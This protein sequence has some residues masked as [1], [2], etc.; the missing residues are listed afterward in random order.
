MD[1]TEANETQ[2][3][4]TTPPTS[5]TSDHNDSIKQL[6][7]LQIPAIIVGIAGLVIWI[8]GSFAG[9]TREQFF[10]SY[11]FAF[12]FWIGIPLGSFALLMLQHLTNGMWG[13]AVR[14][15]LEGAAMTLPIMALLF[16]PIA[17]FAMHDLYKWTIPEIIAADHYILHK[18][19]YLNMPF[20]FG[21]AALYFAFWIGWSIL[22]IKWSSDQDKTANPAIQNRFRMLSGPGIVLYVLTMTFAAFDWGMSVDPHFFSAIYGVI[23]IIGQG[24]ST[25]AFMILILALVARQKPFA[26]FLVSKHFH[27]LG[28]LLFAFTILWTYMS[29]SQFIIIWSGNLPDEVAWYLTRQEGSWN[30][31]A[32]AV[33]LV[34]FVLPFF[35]LLNRFIKRKIQYLWKVALVIFIMRFVDFSWLILPSFNET[36][37]NVHWMTYFAPIGVGGV[38]VFIFIEVLKRRPIIPLGDPQSPNMQ[39][40]MSHG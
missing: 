37:F 4:N 35:L 36:I 22:L 7:R 25:F 27:D 15:L 5:S 17:A 11:L 18:T 1:Q 14:R 12:L 28:N 16:V 3:G 19:P 24:L 23:F 26:D 33:I 21:R 39:E 2:T 30:I 13:F 9:A 20:F 6:T 40:A 8:G 32:V 31:I 29:L 10:Q 34:Q 38:W